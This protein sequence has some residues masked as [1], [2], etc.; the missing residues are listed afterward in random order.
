MQAEGHGWTR[1]DVPMDEL[2]PKRQFF[3]RIV[4]HAGKPVGSEWVEIDKVGL[5]GNKIPPKPGQAL[6]EQTYVRSLLQRRWK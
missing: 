1:V 3:D 2:N 6:V 4:F 5:V